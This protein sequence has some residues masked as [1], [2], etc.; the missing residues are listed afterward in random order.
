MDEWSAFWWYM[1]RRYVEWCPFKYMVL[2][3][4]VLLLKTA[5]TSQL[6]SH[7]SHLSTLALTRDC[8]NC[9]LGSLKLPPLQFLNLLYCVWHV[10]HVHP[11]VTVGWKDSY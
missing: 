7:L 3:V 2:S 8:P 11:L 4:M 1:Q 9:V 5:Q 10:V 6:L